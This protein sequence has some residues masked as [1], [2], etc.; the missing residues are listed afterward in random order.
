MHK[1]GRRWDTERRWQVLNL[2]WGQA[3]QG[4]PGQGDP[5]SHRPP[6]TASAD[7]GPS[8]GQPR[9]LWGTLRSAGSAGSSL[10]WVRG[11][12]RGR[13]GQREGPSR[14]S[15]AAA[16]GT[17]VPRGVQ[18]EP[19]A[20]LLGP[21][22]GSARRRWGEAGRCQARPRGLQRALAQGWRRDRAQGGESLG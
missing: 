12:D 5:G 22:L 8:A 19:V 4:A 11:Q 20:E 18:P 14:F 6:A 16:T 10:R 13:G 21:R 7:S 1:G 9:C 3:R 2:A 17:P 15:P